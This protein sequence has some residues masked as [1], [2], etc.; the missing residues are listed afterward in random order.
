MLEK[1][2]S[3]HI[4]LVVDLNEEDTVSEA[5]ERARTTISRHFGELPSKEDTQ[6]LIDT[7]EAALLAM[8]HEADLIDHGCFE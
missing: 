6:E 2:V 4:E 1:F 8:K 5:V 7:T 3:E